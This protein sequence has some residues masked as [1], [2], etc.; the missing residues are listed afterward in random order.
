MQHFNGQS[1]PKVTGKPVQSVIKEFQRIIASNL[2]SFEKD[3][4]ADSERSSSVA[5]D[6]QDSRPGIQRK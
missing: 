6:A 4:L 1:V 2:T 5:I 3:Y